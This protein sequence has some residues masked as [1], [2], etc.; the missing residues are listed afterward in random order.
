MPSTKRK[1][2]SEARTD[3]LSLLK[4]D[5]TPRA[6]M[7]RRQIEGI[8]PASATRRELDRLAA[9]CRKVQKHYE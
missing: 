2:P 4:G 5:S 6:N 3:A 7:V 1:S 9:L 8:D